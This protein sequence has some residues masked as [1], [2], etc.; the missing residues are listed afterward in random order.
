MVEFDHFKS[1]AGFYIFTHST[2]GWREANSF[3]R[4]QKINKK[5]GMAGNCYA[6]F[7]FLYSMRSETEQSR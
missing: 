1:E 5:S 7:S 3:R 6:R 4:K 2:K